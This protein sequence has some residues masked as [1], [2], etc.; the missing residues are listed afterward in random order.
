MGPLETW[1]LLS[2]RGSAYCDTSA[3]GFGR[4]HTFAGGFPHSPQR[5]MGKT[6]CV[7]PRRNSADDSLLALL[8]KSKRAVSSVP[9]SQ[10]ELLLPGGPAPGTRSPPT[11]VTRVTGYRHYGDAY[12]YSSGRSYRGHPSLLLRWRHSDWD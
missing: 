9:T 11:G 4:F 2:F 7:A 5:P 12:A 1:C 10:T 6:C 3:D 8:T